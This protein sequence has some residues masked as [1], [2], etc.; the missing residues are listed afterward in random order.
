MLKKRL[1]P[2]LIL[3]DGLIVQSIQFKRY[4]PIGK[5]GIAVEFVSNWDVDEIV[6]IDISAT[7]QERKP[8]LELI[9][10][11]SKKCFVPLTI[12]GGIHELETIKDVIRAGADKISINSEAL[13]NPAFITQAADV[14]GAQCIVVSIDV[15]V[16]DKGDYEVV[17]DNGQI[18][19]GK[20]PPEWAKEVEERGAGEIFLNSV[21]Q[22]GMKQGYDLELIRQ[23]S[24]AVRIPVIAC[25][26]VGQFEH[27]VDGVEKGHASAVAA[28]NIFHYTEHSTIVAKAYLQNKDVPVRLNTAAKYD[29]FTFDEH[30]RIQKRDD[31]D[32]ENIWFE[33]SVK[34]KI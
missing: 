15:K 25:G 31:Q 20:N 23:V 24:D 2:C 26:G 11:I 33:R 9:E 29:G 22:D 4:L 18:W 32:L 19:T 5:A 28:G 30:G 7:K 12:G 6:L 10:L 16:N 21:D 8:D 27:L 17:A 1:I 3:K 14:F 13:N 34:E